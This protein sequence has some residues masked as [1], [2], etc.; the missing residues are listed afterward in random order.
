MNLRQTVQTT[1][2]VVVDFMVEAD[3]NRY[4][5]LTSYTHGNEMEREIVAGRLA[6]DMID[7][8]R[9]RIPQQEPIG[10][11]EVTTFDYPF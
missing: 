3:G 6:E 4:R 5:L 10:A 7:L 9:R 1:G 8:V 11:G 2:N